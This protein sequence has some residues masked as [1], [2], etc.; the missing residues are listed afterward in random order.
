[1]G[2]NQLRRN[3]KEFIATVV[4]KTQKIEKAKT[5]KRKGSGSLYEQIK[6]LCKL[7]ESKL[8][9]LRD[10]QICIQD[11]EELNR[12]IDHAIQNGYISLDTETTGLDPITDKIVGA[13]I[14][15]PGEKTA[16]IPINHTSLITGVRLAN[17]LT[18]EQVAKAF[19]RLQENNVKIIYFNAK[20][21]IRVCRH[22]LGIDLPPYWDGFIASKCLKENEEEG[23]LKYLWTKYCSGNREAEHFTF[24]KLFKNYTFNLIPIDVACLYAANDA[25]ITWE[26]FKFQEPYLTEDNERCIECGLQR[27]AKL[28]REIEVPIIMAVAEIEDNGVCIDLDY[29]NELS[30]KY[31]K[32]LKEKSTEFFNELEAYKDQI[33]QYRATHRDSK[34]TDP[35]NINSPTQLAELFYD[36]FKL[37]SVDKKKPRGTGEDILDKLNHPLCKPI[38]DYREVNKLIT[39]YI[40]KMPD[41]RNK[42]TERIH[43]NF[44]QYG[45]DTGR[46]SSSE[47]NLQNIPSHEKSIRRMFC[48][49]KKVVVK[50]IDNQLTLIYGDLVPTTLG[51]KLSQNLVVN[52]IIIGKSSNAK[53]VNINKKDYFIYLILSEER[54]PHV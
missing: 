21:D 32:K 17:Q 20:F 44:N 25:I 53:I 27:V 31:H 11:E 8:G 54:R 3:N 36:I 13:C 47:P 10:T 50:S 34:I 6:E 19:K 40:D 30:E 2:L 48:A 5:A 4:A 35:L 45:A 28:Y 18:N 37:P 1:M 7:V 39:T 14:Y 43:C 24:E 51:N 33:T 46:F 9:H 15:T 38:L 12:Y 29:I 49:S 23:N 42:K 16:Y 26:L 52:D 22:Q 41:I